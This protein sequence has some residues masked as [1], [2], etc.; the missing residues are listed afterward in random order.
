M[1][2]TRPSLSGRAQLRRFPRVSTFRA[3]DRRRAAARTHGVP[4]GLPRDVAAPG[5]AR[6]PPRRSPGPP[7]RSPGPARGPP[8]RSPPGALGIRGGWPRLVDPAAEAPERPGL[9]QGPIPGHR[10]GRPFLAKRGRG[11]CCK[12]TGCG[13]S[14]T[15]SSRGRGSQDDRPGPGGRPQDDQ[16]FG[17]AWACGSR[18]RQGPALGRSGSPASKSAVGAELRAPRPARRRQHE[19]A[20]LRTTSRGTCVWRAAGR[21]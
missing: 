2:S 12:R 15:G 10:I 18:T 3:S 5:K 21:S 1:C 4:D 19:P 17:G 8:G 6:G 9:G 11:R 16:A 7:R 13:R 14:R 20:R